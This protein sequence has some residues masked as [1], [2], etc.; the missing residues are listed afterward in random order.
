MKEIK[1][2]L[3]KWRDILYAWFGRFNVVKDIKSQ[4]TDLQCQ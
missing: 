3:N 4:K 1:V 2:D